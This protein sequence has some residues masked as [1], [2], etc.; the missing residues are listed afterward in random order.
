LTLIGVF[1]A[2]GQHAVHQPHQLVRCRRHCLA[3]ANVALSPKFVPA[4]TPAR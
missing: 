1:L 3:D 2:L 4:P